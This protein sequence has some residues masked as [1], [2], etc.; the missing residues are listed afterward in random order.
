MANNNNFNASKMRPNFFKILKNKITRKSTTASSVPTNS[1]SHY[2]AMRKALKNDKMVSASLNPTLN[3]L[4][5]EKINIKALGEA[6]EMTNLLLKNAYSQLEDLADEVVETTSISDYNIDTSEQI[7][8]YVNS[9]IDKCESKN[10]EI[11]KKSLTNQNNLNSKEKEGQ[12]NNLEDSVSTKLKNIVAKGSIS[13]YIDKLEANKKKTSDLRKLSSKI[14]DN[15]ED[16]TTIRRG[17]NQGAQNQRN[18]NQQAPNG[19]KI[20][21]NENDYELTEE[22]EEEIKDDTVNDGTKQTEEELTNETT[23]DKEKFVR[24][25]SLSVK[26]NESSKSEN[27]NAKTTTIEDDIKEVVRKEVS[28][29]IGQL[30][31]E[32]Q[33]NKKEI[34]KVVRD[35]L[36]KKHKRDLNNIK[37]GLI[38]E[39][40]ADLN[41]IYERED[42]LHP[43]GNDPKTYYSPV[44]MPTHS[45]GQTQTFDLEVQTDIDVSPQ[46]LSENPVEYNKRI[47]IKALQ[48]F[49]HK[50]KW[51]KSYSKLSYHLRIKYHMSVRNYTTY[52]YMKQD[53]RTWMLKN[54]F[55]CDT[56]FDYTFMVSCVNAAFVIQDEEIITREM[57]KN[58]INLPAMEKINNFVAGDLGFLPREG[59]FPC[60]KPKTRVTFGTKPNKIV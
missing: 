33:L 49:A 29:K 24:E 30:K 27:V 20:V 37:N 25:K 60:L 53:A 48:K 58:N 36:I 56:Q 12:S 14:S 45:D 51:I 8:G 57:V 16:V 10:K 6:E 22:L 23:D 38:K 40:A 1:A 55:T 5:K 32:N 17:N 2:Y 47:D 31:K 46:L 26:N 54:G 18:A 42:P 13:T 19:R 43:E 4:K 50:Q 7:T 11:L 44:N 39:I 28:D 15:L 3:R 35:T 21:H 9:L 34:K 52:T 59:I 41:L